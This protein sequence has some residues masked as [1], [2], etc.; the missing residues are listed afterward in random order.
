MAERGATLL[1][2]LVVMGILGLVAGL[3]FPALR[4]PYE[5]LAADTARSA[6]LADLR[7]GRAEAI[8]T[9]APVTFSVS[10]DGRLYGWKDRSRLLPASV[11]MQV[12]SPVT[13]A[14]D[15]SSN[16][17]RLVLY[18]RGRAMTLFVAPAT[19]LASVAATR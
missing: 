16:G 14:E 6:V 5:A 10:P 17:G 4:R 13:F 8:R 11:R 7:T 12:E 2:M 18:A 9:G 15:G 19:G 1:E 3:A